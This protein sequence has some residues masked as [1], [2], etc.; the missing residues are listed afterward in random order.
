MAYL[1]C[2][3][4]AWVVERLDVYCEDEMLSRSDVIRRLLVQFLRT[5]GEP[6]PPAREVRPPVEVTAPRLA[7]TV[8]LPERPVPV[9]V[10]APPA[11]ERTGEHPNRGSFETPAAYAV[12]LAQWKYQQGEE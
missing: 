9:S 6:V 2:R 3:C 4:P 7:P 10:P 12:R 8:P 5:Q 1:A 11:S